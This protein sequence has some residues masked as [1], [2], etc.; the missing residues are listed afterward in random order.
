MCRL[1]SILT[2]EV[3]NDCNMSNATKDCVYTMDE[4]TAQNQW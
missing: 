4:V 2:I 3:G 1:N